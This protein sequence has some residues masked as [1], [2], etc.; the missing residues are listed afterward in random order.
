MAEQTIAV[1]GLA[2][3]DRAFRLAGR[4]AQKRLRKELQAVAEPVRAEAEKLAGATITNLHPGDPWTRMRSV[5]RRNTV[6]VAPVERG[7]GSKRESR[8]RRPN[9]A[10]LLLDRAMDPALEAHVGDTERRLDGLLATISSD[11]ERP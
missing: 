4:N 5:A 3:I 6:Y 1:K 8:R 2:D 9:L 11:W 7:R 10:R